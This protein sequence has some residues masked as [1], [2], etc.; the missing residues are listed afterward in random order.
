MVHRVLSPEPFQKDIVFGGHLCGYVKIP[1]GHVYYQQRDTRDIHILCHGS[2][3]HNA[4]NEDGLN[5]HW[6]GF[7]CAHSG[8]ICPSVENC[9]RLNG[10]IENSYRK[11]MWGKHPH[12]KPTY[13]NI[14]FCVQE[15]MD[16]VDQLMEIQDEHN[17]KPN[18]SQKY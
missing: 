9:K 11:E 10:Y 18:G 16:I 3:T 13:K 15:C 7:D 4:T 17:K 8:D 6:I 12:L 5:S 14:L 1:A 2:I